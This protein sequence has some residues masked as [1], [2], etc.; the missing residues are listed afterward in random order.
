MKAQVGDYL[1]ASVL[2]GA[3]GA[4]RRPLKVVRIDGE[5]ADRYAGYELE[6]GSL[7]GDWEIDDED[8]LLESQA[9]DGP[10]S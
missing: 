4:G 5:P 10:G 1:K 9:L 3:A 8:V 2:H 6:D 7:I